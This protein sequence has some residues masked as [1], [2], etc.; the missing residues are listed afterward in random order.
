[1]IDYVEKIINMYRPMK[2]GITMGDP[3]GIGPE[4]IAKALTHETLQRR[5][6]YFVFGNRQVFRKVFANL[7]VALSIQPN[8][9]L[10]GLEGVVFEDVESAGEVSFTPGKTSP[11]AGRASVEY[12]I[13]AIKAVLSGKLDALVTA[14]ICKESVKAAG[15]AYSGHTEILASQTDSRDALMMFVAGDLRVGVATR[16]IPLRKIPGHL[17]LER[18]H[19]SISVLH[20]TLR[21]LWGL[22]CPVIAVAALNPHA[23]EGGTLGSEEN[24][25]IAP[26]IAYARAHGIRCEGP[27]PA[28]AIFLPDTAS[29]FDGILTMYHD[30]ALIP[31]K[32]LHRDR[33]V[34]LTA[35]LPFIR[36]SPAHGTAFSIAGKGIANPSSM[37]AAIELACDLVR[38][39]SARTLCNLPLP[40]GDH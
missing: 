6:T 25:L 13:A 3:C 4:I 26:A 7:G 27:F 17:T 30:Q 33:L 32:L 39:T 20:K 1:M 2:I 34:N 21:E 38:R 40:F 10:K 16:H 19:S 9:E 35:G 12:V 22:Q 23:G 15:Y 8:G 14:P 11:E 18:I 36:T 37:I 24:R 29:R 28:D 31:L 5:A